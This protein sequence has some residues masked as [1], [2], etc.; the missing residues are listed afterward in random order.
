MSSRE[1]SFLCRAI[2]GDFTAK[3]TD[4]LLTQNIDWTTVARLAEYH[5]V[6]PQLL[7]SLRQM[8]CHLPPDIEQLLDE[9]QQH[10]LVRSL[11]VGAKLLDIA[12]AF[13]EK[14][15]RFATFK[16][17]TLAISLYGDLFGREFNDI[18]L[19][20]HEADLTTAEN[21][22]GSLGYRAKAGDRSYRDAFLAYQ[23][24]YIF[25]TSETMIDLHWDFTVRGVPFPLRGREIWGQLESVSIA[26]REV[27]T[28]GRSE[29]ALYLAGHGAKH[30]W[31]SLSWLCDFANF[32]RAYPDV[33][34]VALWQRS[35]R[36]HCGNP[37][38]QGCTLAS[39]LLDAPVDEEL[40][41]YADR[42]PAVEA[43]ADAAVKRM[44]DPPAAAAAASTPEDFLGGLD[45]CETWIQ[46]ARILWGLASTR[47]TGDYEA[48]PLPPALWRLYH[49][50]RPFRLGIKAL[51]RA[52]TR[53]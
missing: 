34:W 23:N 50:S 11:Q 42:E 40:L 51:S 25:Q 8:D 5:G 32:I 37:V 48:M 4:D 20:V 21:C 22:L 19:I 3:R 1:F 12:E 9:F 36:K 43:L 39:N 15:L 52:R 18:D 49:L 41:A 38:L 47:T 26:G 53:S 28:L 44:M 29:L 7:H 17:V 46:K 27:P 30:G 2:S 24:Q 16:G 14:G 6:R 45:L 33:D 35:D 31:N 13:G 10:H